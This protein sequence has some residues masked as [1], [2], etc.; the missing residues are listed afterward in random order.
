[1]AD[2]GRAALVNAEGDVVDLGDGSDDEEEAH[3]ISDQDDDIDAAG[4]CAG[5]DVAGKTR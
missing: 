2:S 1:M 5:A 3:A 4:A